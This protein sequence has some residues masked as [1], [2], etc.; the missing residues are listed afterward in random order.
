MLKDRPAMAQYGDKGDVLRQWAARKFAGEDLHQ[1]IFW[2]A[3]DPPPHATSACPLPTEHYPGR[4]RV[5]RDCKDG[6]D[7]GKERPFEE[8]WSKAVFELYNITGAKEF[9]H[10]DDEAAHD[11]LSKEQYATKYVE[12]ESL[13]AEKTAPSTSTSSSRGQRNI[14]FPPNRTSGILAGVGNRTKTSSCPLWPRATPIG[15]TMNVIMTSQS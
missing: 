12:V 10:A 7:K 2:D 3:S 14:V 11:M 15:R 13:A 1:E 9:Q 4:I 6:P 8:M 5:R